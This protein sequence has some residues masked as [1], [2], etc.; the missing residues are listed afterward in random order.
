LLF[1]LPEFHTDLGI[2]STKLNKNKRKRHRQHICRVCLSVCL[3]VYLCVCLST[4][5]W[6][7]RPKNLYVDSPMHAHTSRHW[8]RYFNVWNYASL[9]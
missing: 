1:L 5:S 6:W 7:L 8:S 3:S 9:S 2:L 4:A